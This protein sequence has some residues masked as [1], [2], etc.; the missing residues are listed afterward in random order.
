MTWSTPISHLLAGS[1]PHECFLKI[2]A[3]MDEEDAMGDDWRKLWSELV[4]QPLDEA[5]AKQNPEGPTIYTL[6]LWVKAQRQQLED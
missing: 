5:V 1:P 4:K 3:M 6:K 2:A